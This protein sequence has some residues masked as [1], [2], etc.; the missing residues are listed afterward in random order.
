MSACALE[1]GTY[2]P[3]TSAKSIGM[4]AILMGPEAGMFSV[5]MGKPTENCGGL[6]TVRWSLSLQ[7]DLSLL[8]LAWVGADGEFD[9]ANN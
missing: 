1:R 9:N 6:F 8:P 4:N 2:E 3:G 7:S 5:F